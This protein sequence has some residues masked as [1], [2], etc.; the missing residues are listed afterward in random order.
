MVMR[1]R[2]PVAKMSPGAARLTA[3]EVMADLYRTLDDD[4]GHAWLKD[5]AKADRKVKRE[6]RDPWA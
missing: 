3:L 6:T 4:E 1:G 5:A 2:H